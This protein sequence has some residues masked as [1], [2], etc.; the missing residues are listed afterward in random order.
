MLCL[1]PIK[2]LVYTTHILLLYRVHNS[3]VD[4]RDDNI[5][6]VFIVKRTYDTNTCEFAAFSEMTNVYD[7]YVN[8]AH[9]KQDFIY[10]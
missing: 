3:D 9:R 1:D 6:H 10:E 5:V 2:T 4:W 8:S 7:F